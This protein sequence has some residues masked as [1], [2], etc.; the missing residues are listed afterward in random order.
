MQY[1]DTV[2]TPLQITYSTLN[3]F[4]NG[5]A[6]NQANEL[7]KFKMVNHLSAGSILKLFQ[8]FLKAKACT[9]VSYKQTVR[10]GTEN[11]QVTS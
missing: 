1:A 9:S 3:T 11:T 8:A 10:S 6:V 5:Y 2:M 4:E 7:F